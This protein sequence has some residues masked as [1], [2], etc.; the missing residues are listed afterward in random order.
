MQEKFYRAANGIFGTIGRTASEEVILISSFPVN[1]HGLPILLYGLES[2]SLFKY[3]PNS[4][5]FTENSF[6]YETV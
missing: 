1:A 6:F 5:D 4:L 2:L 3:Q